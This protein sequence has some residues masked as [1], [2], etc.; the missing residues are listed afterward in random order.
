MKISQDT[1]AI[2]K[3]FSTINSNLLV[4]EG[5]YLTTISPTK[6]ILA[7]ANVSETFDVEFGIWD[8]SKFLATVSLFKDPEFNFTEDHVEISSEGS[9]AAIKYYYS[10]PELLVKVDKKLK[11]P[12]TP[13]TFTLTSKDYNELQKASSVLQA[14]DLSLESTE[15]NRMV[16]RVFDRKDSTS[17][18]YSIDM[19]ENKSGTS[20]SFLF[21]TENLKMIPGTYEV[22]ISEKKVSQFRN[23]NGMTYWISLEADSVFEGSNS[24]VANV[25]TR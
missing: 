9:K 4:K 1:L 14:P 25:A 5:S 23:A 17:H 21:K 7:E 13:V 2:L 22:G 3:N 6:N 24:K 18:S 11:M 10:E 12:T 20:F 8:L 16:M 15:D 19:G